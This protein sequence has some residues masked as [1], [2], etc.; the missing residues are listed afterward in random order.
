M[1]PGSRPDTVMEIDR[2]ILRWNNA[3]PNEKFAPQPP[4]P[5]WDKTVKQPDGTKKEVQIY[6]TDSEYNRFLQIAGRSAAARLQVAGLNYD[7]PT[8]ADLEKIDD[9][10]AK[11]R[12]AARDTVWTER[13]TRALGNPLKTKP[14]PPAIE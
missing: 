9:A 5:K 2:M 10:L 1:T 3:N 4:A 13:V 7:N 11:S 6:M 14:A 8:K 12:K